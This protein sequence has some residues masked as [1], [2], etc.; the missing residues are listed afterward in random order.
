MAIDDLD[1]RLDADLTFAGPG[2]DQIS[3]DLKAKGH[4]WIASDGR[5]RPLQLEPF[6]ATIQGPLSNGGGVFS[7]EDIPV[8]LLALFAPVPAS[9]RGAAGL[10]GRYRLPRT[11][12]T[13]RRSCFSMRRP[14]PRRPSP[15]NAMPF[16]LIPQA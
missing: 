6:V 4:L 12:Q 9:L 16:S 3:I 8:G 1:G 2:I 5:D 11:V 15:L 7:L 13:L 14:S 10:R